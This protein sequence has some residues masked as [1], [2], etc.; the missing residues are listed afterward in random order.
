[1]TTTTTPTKF[2]TP[3]PI[4][5][6]LRLRKGSVLVRAA[7]R[8][9]TIVDVRPTDES[10][11]SDVWAAE[12]TTVE[13]DG[14]VL[15]VV[16]PERRSM[17]A[18]ESIAV[19]VDLPTGSELNGKAAS[20]AVRAH[21][22]LGPADFTVASGDLHLDRTAGARLSAAS[23]DLTV[24]RIDGD[25]AVSAGSGLIRL[26]QVEGGATAKAGSGRV[27]I[28]AVADDVEVKVASG[29]VDIGRCDG[30]VEVRTASGDVRVGQIRRGVTRVDSASGSVEVG[31]GAGTAAWLDLG[32]KSGRVRSD[33]DDSAGPGEGDE[34]A[35]VRVATRSGDVTIRRAKNDQG[36]AGG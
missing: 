24:G 5:T 17:F 15:R 26:G 27:E 6:E 19:T 11:A 20:A 12:H 23:G 8:T 35:E 31:I 14:R 30:S 10:D 36:V 21:G 9:E 34:R 13:L 32:S 7:E 22:R 29:R 18:S 3:T 1:M 28:G 33:L 2:D 4:S 16:A 25:A